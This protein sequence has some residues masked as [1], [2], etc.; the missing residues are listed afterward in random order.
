MKVSAAVIAIALCVS[1]P[2]YATEPLTITRNAK[3]I[4][5]DGV[6]I[7]RVNRVVTANDTVT[8]IQLIVG[9]RLVVI[10]ADTLSVDEI[11]VKT[12]LSRKEVRAL[13]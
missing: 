12:T 1:V 4:S 2:A 7:G 9:D 5:S 3:V 13:R 11:G 6:A 10:P 8:G